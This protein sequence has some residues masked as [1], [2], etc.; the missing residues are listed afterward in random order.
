M[1][2]TKGESSKIEKEAH[3]K[4]LQLKLIIFEKIILRLRALHTLD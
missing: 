4:R 1:L 2:Y 3:C